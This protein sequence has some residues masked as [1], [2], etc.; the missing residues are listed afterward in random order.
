MAT[1]R[2]IINDALKQIGA[3]AIGETATAEE[4]DDA[5]G[6][7]NDML[8][9]WRTESLLVYNIDSNVFP[10]TAGKSYYTIGIGGDFNVERPIRIESAY[11]RDSNGNDYKMVTTEDSQD[12]SDLIAKYVTSTI[13]YLLYDNG[14]F[15]LK[16]LSI[17]PVPASGTY[18]LVLWTWGV[19]AEFDSLNTDI[20][21]P[22]GYK[23]A[24]QNNL[25]F[26]L[27]PRYGITN[28]AEI[29]KAATRTK[30]QIKRINTVTP[31]MAFPRSL[32]GNAV[33][34]NWLTGQPT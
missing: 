3:L 11:V 22:P 32:T 17:W 13:P 19:L 16:G 25:A 15:P 18:S 2:D 5:L 24:I 4:A 27:C 33:A 8:D 31:T 29:E 10:F 6:V 34:F 7:L 26:M 14:N 28:V 21:L 9:S 12:Y 1:A 30:A 23:L 20:Q